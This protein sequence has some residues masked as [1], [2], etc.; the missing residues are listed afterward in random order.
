MIAR[1]TAIAATLVTAFALTG[2]ANAATVVNGGFEAGLSGWNQSL[3]NEL[4][5]SWVPYTGNGPLPQSNDFVI[6]PFAGL[7]AAASDEFENSSSSLY[8][9]VNLEAGFTHKFE[10]KHGWE[11]DWSGGWATPSPMNFA[12]LGVVDNQQ[13]RVDVIKTSADPRTTNS[14]D[15]LATSFQ[16]DPSVPLVSEWTDGPSLDLTPFAGQTVRLRFIYVADESYL[17]HVIDEVKITS[18]NIKPPTVSTAKL[19][20]TK[21][22]AK[23]SASI[24]FTTD[25]AGTATI[26]LE[27][28]AKGKRV[29]KNCVRPS[30]KNSKKRDCKRWVALKGA[31]TSAVVVGANKLTVSATK[32]LKPG[33]YRAKLFVTDNGALASVPVYKTFTVVAKK[34]KKR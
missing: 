28:S 1:L 10:Y 3:F 17:H 23:K 29:G 27:K 6:A 18:N 24:R 2:S 16:T 33:K 25:E 13:L 20:T 4:S 9:D 12:L 8:Q 22:I 11:N 15:I 30:R 26:L 14:A 32:K 21:L 19:S 7:G 34:K 31:Q 5:G